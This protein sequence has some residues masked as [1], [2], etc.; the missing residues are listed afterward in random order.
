MSDYEFFE[1]EVWPQIDGCPDDDELS[2]EQQREADE[3]YERWISMTEEE[4]RAERQKELDEIIKAMKE[5]GL[6]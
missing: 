1:E 4:R 3:G 6:A 5:V 2:E